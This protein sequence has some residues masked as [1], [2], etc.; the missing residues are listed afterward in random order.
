MISKDFP[1]QS[2]AGRRRQT[3]SQ[4]VESATMDWADCWA[5]CCADWLLL[6]LLPELLRLLMLLLALAMLMRVRLSDHGGT[7]LT[8]LALTCDT[9][10]YT[11]TYIYG[12]VEHDWSVHVSSWQLTHTLLWAKIETMLLIQCRACMSIQALH[13]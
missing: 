6:L 2:I 4:A 12:N 5:E 9:H 10:S 8:E 1:L 3:L 11:H 7:A 13:G